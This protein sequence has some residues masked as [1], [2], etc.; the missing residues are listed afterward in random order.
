MVASI[1]R[2]QSSLNFLLNQILICHS[3]SQVSGCAVE[4]SLRVISSQEVGSFAQ[5]YSSIILF[6]LARYE[7]LRQIP[8]YLP[9]IV[10]EYT[11][12][13]PLDSLFVPYV[14]CIPFKCWLS[15]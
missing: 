9:P 7:V 4:T 6:V 12:A 2:I 14:T 10:T 15:H 5:A 3:R 1:T 13:V 8:S 11:P